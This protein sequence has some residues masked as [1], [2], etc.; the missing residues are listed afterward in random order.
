MAIDKIGHFALHTPG[1]IYDTEAMTSLELAARTAGKVNEV[2]EDQNNLRDTTTQRL[3]EIPADVSREVKKHIDNGAFDTQIDKHTEALL[4]GIEA[5]EEEMERELNATESSLGHRLDNLLGKVSEGST[6]MDAEIIDARIGADKVTYTSVGKAIRDQFDKKANVQM[7]NCGFY[8]GGASSPQKIDWVRVGNTDAIDL[9]LYGW[10]TFRTSG[11]SD[12]SLPWATIGTE[13]ADVM[14]LTDNDETATIRL[15]GWGRSL[16]YNFTDKLLHIRERKVRYHDD[17]VLVVNGYGNPCGGELM[18]FLDTVGVSD[19][20]NSI[21]YN[22][23]LYIAPSGSDS[24]IKHYRNGAA[25]T[26]VVPN[27]IV[28]RYKNAFEESCPWLTYGSP[29]VDNMV[30]D[31]YAATITIPDYGGRLVFNVKDKKYYIRKRND[32]PNEND[33]V[34]MVNGYGTPCGGELMR[35]I[36]NARIVALEEKTANVSAIDVAARQKVMEYAALFNNTTNVESFMFF[37]DPHLTQ[38]S[39]E[40]WRGEFNDYMAYMGNVYAEAPVSRVFCGGDWL[41]HDELPAEACYRLGLINATLRKNFTE[42]HHVLGNHDTNYQGK[43][44]ASAERWTGT[45][46]NETI[47]NLLYR[48]EG[49]AYFKVTGDKTDFYVFDTQT[50]NK[51]V[52]EYENKQLFWFAQSLLESDTENIALML[53]MLNYNGESIQPLTWWVMKIAEAYNNRASLTVGENTDEARLFDFAACKGKVRFAM[54]GHE[55]ADYVRTVNGIPV[56]TTTHT[57]DGGVPTFDL[58]LADYDDN[59]LRLVRV[60]TGENRTISI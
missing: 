57:R 27:Q 25:L 18:R 58:C 52:S 53:H 34:L 17:F 45:I 39:G 59:V 16:V 22:H 20:L 21:V 9:T 11:Q 7:V 56:I 55:H 43:A 54:T 10:I 60:G 12:N 36:T 14:T 3:G 23:G 47:R 13:I 51:Q 6:T 26:I 28:F 35:Y 2:V 30:V 40:A 49:R 29:I 1:T 44:N 42:Y 8:I 15:S 48:R 32:V 37:T 5:R 33:I 4:K 31:G 50:E 41:G 46:T 19:K 24:P 38:F